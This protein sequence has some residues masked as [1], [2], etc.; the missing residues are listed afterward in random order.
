ME[1][2]SGEEE[3]CEEDEE[4][5]EELPE[6][7][8]VGCQLTSCCNAFRPRHCCRVCLPAQGWPR[9]AVKCEKVPLPSLALLLPSV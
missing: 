7:V 1:S 3:E 5:V 8:Q 6:K 4:E 2:D 9:A